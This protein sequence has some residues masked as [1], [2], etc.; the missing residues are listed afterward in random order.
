MSIPVSFWTPSDN[1]LI[2]DDRLNA[3]YELHQ[4]VALNAHVNILLEKY[5]IMSPTQK[6]AKHL[7]LIRF[8]KAPD[9]RY[10]V[11]QDNLD[12]LYVIDYMRRRQLTKFLR[13]T[14]HS[15]NEDEF[16]WLSID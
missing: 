15:S 5:R 2:P 3:E 12:A 4:N 13:F 10:D 6:K 7:F 1:G 11:Q 9:F 14:L 16:F 8:L